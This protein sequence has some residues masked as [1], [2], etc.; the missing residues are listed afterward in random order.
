MRIIQITT[1]MVVILIAWCLLTI[2]KRGY[3]PVPLLTKA[4]LHFGPDTLG[5]LEGTVAPG[6]TII[7]VM[8]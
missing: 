7:A 6:I 1:V 8:I 3:Q 2:W 5:W 4:N